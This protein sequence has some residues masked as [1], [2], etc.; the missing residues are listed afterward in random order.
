MFNKYIGFNL[1]SEIFTDQSLGKQKIQLSEACADGDLTRV[2][3]LLLE[4]RNLVNV[5]FFDR[6]PLY[7]AIKY[8]ITEG[9]RL[10]EVVVST[11]HYDVAV[12][13]VRS[14][15]NLNNMANVDTSRWIQSKLDI[16]NAILKISRS[17]TCYVPRRSNSTAF[18]ETAI[19]A[20]ASIVEPSVG[21]EETKSSEG[22]A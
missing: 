22:P 20:R 17:L 3:A 7:T 13:L 8:A 19:S 10:S 5:T 11:K 4:N 15:A 12:F 1:M 16:H 21:A 6:Y 18:A 14:G 2:K 9:R